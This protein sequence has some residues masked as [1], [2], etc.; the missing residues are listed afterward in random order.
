LKP[1]FYS[2]RRCLQQFNEQLFESLN[3]SDQNRLLNELIAD[4][5]QRYEKYGDS[6][7]VLEPNVKFSAG[8]LRDFQLD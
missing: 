1:G 4:R 6:P 7:K 8:G 2:V 5:Q 3:Y